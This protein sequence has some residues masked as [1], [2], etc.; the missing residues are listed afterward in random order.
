MTAGDC[1]RGTYYFSKYYTSELRRVGTFSGLSPNDL[2]PE[3]PR[4][5]DTDRR[6]RLYY[7]QQESMWASDLTPEKVITRIGT[8]HMTRS[9]DKH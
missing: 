4:L 3:V 6:L 8:Q 7:P 1:T 9:T 5:E 2:P